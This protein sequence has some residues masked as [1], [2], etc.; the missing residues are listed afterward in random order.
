[1]VE[2]ASRHEPFLRA[3]VL[4]SA[5]HPEVRRRGARYSQ[6]LGE[7]FA[8]VVLAA[9]GAIAHPDPA[10]AVHACFSTV[11]AASIFVFRRRFP[12]DRV[13]LPYRCPLYPVLPAIY[14][15][16][17]AIVLLNM[18]SEQYQEAMTGVAFIGV[19]AI[20][21]VLFGCRSAPVSP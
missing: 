16:A 6:E 18:F 2:I 7:G 21:Y 5:A 12:R 15:I 10:A 19:G 17:L 9:A 20:V 11:F 8:G 14:V 3:V 4:T 1:M 13:S